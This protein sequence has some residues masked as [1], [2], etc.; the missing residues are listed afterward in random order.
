MAPSIWTIPERNFLN[1]YRTRHKTPDEDG[2]IILL[3]AKIIPRFLVEFYGSAQP[4]ESDDDEGEQ[5]EEIEEE[6]ESSVKQVR[7]P[8]PW[9]IGPFL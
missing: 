3:E 8:S 7:V 9:D 2:R 4:S 1:A 5:D 6:K